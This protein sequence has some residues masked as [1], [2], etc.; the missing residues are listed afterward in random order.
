MMTGFRSTEAMAQRIRFAAA[1][2]LVAGATIAVPAQQQDTSTPD[3]RLEGGWVRLDLAG[4]GSFGG[5]TSKFTPAEL[6]PEAA[7]RGRGAGGRGGAGRGGG[8]AGRGTAAAAGGTPNPAGVPYVAVATPCSNPAG[9]GNGALLLNPDSGGVHFIEHKGEIIFAGE[10]GGVRHIYMDGRAHPAHWTPTPAGH[11]VG[12]YE[13]GTLVVE[14]VG[15]TAGTVVAG[16]LR[17]PE[18]KLIERFEVSADGRR[19]TI[20]YTWDDPKIY[21]RSHTYQIFMERLP[22][23]SYALE[24][25]CDASDPIEQQSI[26]PPKQ[27]E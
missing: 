11:S 3:R 23:G 1:M 10:R 14:T 13:G 21:R 6:L 9:R 12:R 19:L 26:V 17:T 27:L 25:W 24:E 7:A 4:S 16:G 18:T 22:A 5:L 15:M 8:P 2:A 20:A